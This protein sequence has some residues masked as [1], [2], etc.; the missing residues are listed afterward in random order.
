MNVTVTIALPLV[1]SLVAINSEY[2][3]YALLSELQ[4][5]MQ[6]YLQRGLLMGLPVTLQAA[7][8]YAWQ[9]LTN[10]DPDTMIMSDLMSD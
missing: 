10:V 5:T 1:E 8:D 9:E 7:F 2:C 6:T 3:G 4:T